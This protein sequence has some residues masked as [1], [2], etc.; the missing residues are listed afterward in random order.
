LERGNTRGI[1]LWE[2]KKKK[3]KQKKVIKT[4]CQTGGGNLYGRKR[5][6]KR[7]TPGASRKKVLVRKG[8][9]LPI[10]GSR[11]EWGTLGKPKEKAIGGDGGITWKTDGKE[12][13]QGGSV[14]TVYWS[15]RTRGSLRGEQG[16][17][18][19]VQRRGE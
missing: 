15:L 7:L 13:I 11:K 18:R 3:K 19:A 2:K 16:A 17:L 10:P 9:Y 12:G 4:I 1:L 14:A 6:I 8:E 5:F